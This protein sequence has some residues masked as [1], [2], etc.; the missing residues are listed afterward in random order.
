M[1]RDNKIA[2]VSGLI[3]GASVVILIGLIIYTLVTW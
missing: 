1:R 3:L 2:F